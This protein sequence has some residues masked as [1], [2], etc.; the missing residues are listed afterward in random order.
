MRHLTAKTS[1]RA[2]TACR[3]TSPF[4]WST[5][6]AT[7]VPNASL[8]TALRPK[9]SIRATMPAILHDGDATARAPA[10]FAACKPRHRGRADF[11]HLFRLDSGLHHSYSHDHPRRRHR[12]RH[13]QF[14]FDDALDDEIVSTTALYDTRG[15]RHTKNTRQRVG[16]VSDLADYTISRRHACP[17]GPCWPGSH[18]DRSSI[19]AYFAPSAAAA[20]PRRRRRSSSRWRPG[21]P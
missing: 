2:T 13:H 1:A 6:R 18:R 20:R 8:D 4:W 10:G 15:A 7:P 19:S 17:T 11:R 3:C 12:I 14:V 9:A 5:R 16:G 21:G